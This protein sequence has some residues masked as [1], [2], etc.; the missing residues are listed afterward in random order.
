M[1]WCVR[2]LIYLSLTKL[3][4]CSNVFIQVRNICFADTSHVV[5]LRILFVL[6]EKLGTFCQFMVTH[7]D[8]ISNIFLFRYAS[9][10]VRMKLL[11]WCRVKSGEGFRVG[12]GRA[13]VSLSQYFG[14]ISSLHTKLFYNIK[15]NDFFLS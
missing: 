12:S 13:R 8:L 11:T 9:R 15:S 1:L 10:T 6:K 14:L 2:H 5:L 3:P 7:F 4:Q